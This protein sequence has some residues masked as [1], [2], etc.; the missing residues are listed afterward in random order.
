MSR[1]LACF[2]VDVCLCL[3]VCITGGVTDLPRS[4]LKRSGLQHMSVSAL[5]TFWPLLYDLFSVFCLFLTSMSVSH[6]FCHGFMVF[7]ATCCCFSLLVVALHS[8]YTSAVQVLLFRP[9]IVGF[10]APVSS[11]SV[12]GCFAN[13]NV[14]RLYLF[15]CIAA[16]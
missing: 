1:L 8:M 4:N 5:R 14:L 16:L 11:G 2:S 7:T 12:L 15:M 13:T 3:L 10:A 6:Y 9:R